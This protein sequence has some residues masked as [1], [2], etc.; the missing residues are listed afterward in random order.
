MP[1]LTSGITVID[2]DIY[3]AVDLSGAARPGLWN[4][5]AL[6][7]SPPTL[8]RRALRETYFS[9][10][11]KK[12]TATLCGTMPVAGNPATVSAKIRRP[13]CAGCASA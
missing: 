11:R 9:H 2:A 8:R 10:I 1:S 13:M 5:L 3:R 12:S 6:S 7:L 4:I